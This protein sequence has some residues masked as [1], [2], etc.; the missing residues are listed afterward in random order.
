M[1]LMKLRIMKWICAF[2]AIL[3][4]LS[5][6]SLAVDSGQDISIPVRKGGFEVNT[7]PAVNELRGVVNEYQP[8]F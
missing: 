5:G 7:S 4:V 6:C 2:A 8:T 3:G 1:I